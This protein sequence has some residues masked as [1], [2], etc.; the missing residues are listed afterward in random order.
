MSFLALFIVINAIWNLTLPLRLQLTLGPVPVCCPCPASDHH[1]WH[2]AYPLYRLFL[3]PAL[4]PV[5]DPF[6]NPTLFPLIE[7]CWVVF[8]TGSRFGLTYNQNSESESCGLKGFLHFIFYILLHS[9]ST[10]LFYVSLIYIFVTL[11]LVYVFTASCTSII[12]SS[13]SFHYCYSGRASVYLL[14]NTSVPRGMEGEKF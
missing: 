3:F 14:W 6:L 12:T 1:N 9:E 4:F 5:M 2:I 13:Y 10:L 8:G 11:N 7:H